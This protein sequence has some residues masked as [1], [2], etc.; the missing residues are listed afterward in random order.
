MAEHTNPLDA[1]NTAYFKKFYDLDVTHINAW[2]ILTAKKRDR[3]NNSPL[4][5]K[6]HR[7]HFAPM[8]IEN[9]ALPMFKNA[10]FATAR[11]SLAARTDIKCAC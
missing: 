3:S 9:W 5:Q 2:R 11:V 1:L 7:T 6:Q 8:I 4:K 10:G